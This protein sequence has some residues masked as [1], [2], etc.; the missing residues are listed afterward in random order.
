ML[1]Q[2][3]DLPHGYVV[4]A[5]GH[6]SHST[7][8]IRTPGSILLTLLAVAATASALID[9][10]ASQYSAPVL[11]AHVPTHWHTLTCALTRPAESPYAVC[12]TTL[13]IVN[14]VLASMGL[15][16]AIRYNRTLVRM[17]MY[18]VA[19][20]AVILGVLGALLQAQSAQL[21]Q[22]D[23]HTR[24]QA[25]RTGDKIKLCAA[26][27]SKT[28]II[29]CAASVAVSMWTL[30]TLW[31]F[32]TQ[33][34]RIEKGVPA[35]VFGYTIAGPCACHCGFS[36]IDDHCFTITVSKQLHSRQHHTTPH[37]QARSTS[38][39][40]SRSTTQN[41]PCPTPTCR[42]ASTLLQPMGTPTDLTSAVLAYVFFS[43]CPA[44]VLPGGGRGRGA[45]GAGGRLRLA[46]AIV[47]LRQQ[48]EVQVANLCLFAAY[49]CL[50]AASA[51]DLEV[52]VCSSPSSPIYLLSVNFQD[53]SLFAE[54][55]SCKL[56]IR[57]MTQVLAGSGEYT[58]WLA[59]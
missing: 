27:T 2:P 7:H 8:H 46:G 20:H 14:V 39:L 13:A 54:Q 5:V 31:R 6:E 47:G 52:D 34:R 41:S 1:L 33:L 59:N 12:T 28:I 9:E 43:S 42:S 51:D 19:L 10:D 16:G 40:T 23:F 58:V 57:V 30:H 44:Q 4:V 32:D 48:G 37:L 17:Y 56:G 22:E 49:L 55:Q 53:N 15:L 35:W 24:D 36:G 26:S 29:S 38:K 45:G 3:H 21:C 50:F 11:S 25:A 18:W